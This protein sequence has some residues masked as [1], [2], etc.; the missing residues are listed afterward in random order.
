M[1]DR[2]YEQTNEILKSLD[3]KINEI[4][5]GCKK[6]V[7]II[8]DNY[9]K[10]A[11]GDISEILDQ[12]KKGKIDNKKSKSLLT[13]LL[14]GGK[15][16]SEFRD[17]TITSIEKN[18]DLACNIINKNM[19]I[20]Y[21]IN[22]IFSMFQIATKTKAKV[23]LKDEG[24][25][26]QWVKKNK[27]GEEYKL[28]KKKNVRFN[29]Q[30]LKSLFLG[31]IL[32]LNISKSIR[33]AIEKLVDSNRNIAQKNAWTQ[34]TKFQN[35]GRNDRYK[36]AFNQGIDIE[37]R[38]ITM[39]D[40]RVRETHSRLNGATIEIDE[41]FDNSC[42]YPGDYSHGADISEVAQ[43]RCMLAPVIDGEQIAD[44]INGIPIVNGEYIYYSMFAKYRYNSCSYS[45]WR[46][47]TE[48][49]RER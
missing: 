16:W 12:K 37:K 3:D 15:L 21:N 32:G 46:E 19:P 45:E 11:S 13:K 20:I 18:N 4:Y 35:M 29:K 24:D 14:I 42:L 38:W 2:A 44:A 23:K 25:I 47:M 6:E 22:S 40:N 1:A 10:K 5:D 43:C 48:S 8:C 27:K 41:L 17:K 49:F 33:K 9:I 31:A 26:D 30:K 34:A 39:G 28:N 7:L 36:E